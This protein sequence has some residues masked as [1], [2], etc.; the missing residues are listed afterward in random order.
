MSEVALA[1]SAVSGVLRAA[2]FM[3]YAEPKVG[4][5]AM[6]LRTFPRAIM[7]GQRSAIQLVAQATC[8]F[9]PEPW[10]IIENLTTLEHIVWFLTDATRGLK[11]PGWQAA[12][13]QHGIDSI[14]IDDFSQICSKSVILWQQEKTGDKYHKYNKLDQYLDWISFLLRDLGMLCGMSAHKLEPKYDLNEKSR[15]FGKLIAMGAPEVPSSKQVQAVPGWVDFVAPMRIGDSLDPWWP[16]VIAV[17]AGESKLWLAGDRNNVCWGS[18]PANLREILL[19]ARAPD[20]TAI[21]TLPRLPRLAFQDEYAD[22][23]ANALDTGEPMKDIVV[24]MF[25][26][27]GDYAKPRTPGELHIQWAIQDGIARHTIR[28]QQNLGVLGRFLATSAAPPPPPPPPG[29]AVPAAPP[30]AAGQAPP[31]PGK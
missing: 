19:A 29:E 5:T 16:R 27:A 24:R 26:Q 4:K 1:L 12:I 31:I 18:T 21:Y 23:V 15:T 14:Y 7:I 22:A 2:M 30:P 10:Q 9:T 25:R 20:G 6:F 17:D 13:K 3:V 11:S 28:A 8:G